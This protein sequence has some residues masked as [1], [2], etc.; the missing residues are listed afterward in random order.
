MPFYFNALRVNLVA[1][2]FNPSIN[3]GEEL[4]LSLMG[5]FF[6]IPKL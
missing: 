3:T 5:L 2:I 6:I 4:Q 1:G